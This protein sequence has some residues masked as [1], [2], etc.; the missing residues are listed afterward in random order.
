M[1]LGVAMQISFIHSIS[2]M[3]QVLY[4]ALVNRKLYFT[5]FGSFDLYYIDTEGLQ[6]GGKVVRAGRKDPRMVFLGVD[7]FK[8][9]FRLAG[10][11]EVLSWDTRTPL[12]Q[13][14][15]EMVDRCEGNMN[16]MAAVPN[17]GRVW[18]LDGD[19]KSF[20][21]GEQPKHRFRPANVNGTQ[22]SVP[23]IEE[24]RTV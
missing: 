16:Q 12:T 14:N 17:F 18:I 23:E 19:V 15:L 2:N 21:N 22:R 9:V 8:I 10:T 11:N 7:G 13:E 4:T 1:I 24:I 3:L 20:L 6:S 5:Y